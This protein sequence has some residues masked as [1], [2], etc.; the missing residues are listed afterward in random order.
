MMENQNMRG[1]FNCQHGGGLWILFSFSGSML[2]LCSCTI[3]SGRMCN[4]Q[5]IF[6][7][8]KCMRVTTQRLYC[9][10]EHILS[11]SDTL[12]CRDIHN[13]HMRA[14]FL[15]APLLSVQQPM[16]LLQ[17]PFVFGTLL[18]S[19]PPPLESRQVF[20]APWSQGN[21]NPNHTHTHT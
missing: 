12:T 1:D 8:A 7:F 10:H 5:P 11:H 20:I 15:S 14:H 3:K 21:P 17:K 19:S 18:Y 16:W 2:K 13:Q 4:A 6:L 9:A